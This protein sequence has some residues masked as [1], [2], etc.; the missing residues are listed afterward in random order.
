MA[1]DLDLD[2]SLGLGLLLFLMFELALTLGV[3]PGLL[4][5]PIFDEQLPAGLLERS[6]S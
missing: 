5:I 2:L 1:R 4:D 3:R 6:G